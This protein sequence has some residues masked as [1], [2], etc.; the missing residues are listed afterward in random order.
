MR[1]TRILTLPVEGLAIPSQQMTLREIATM[2][3]VF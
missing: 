2:Q 1:V 3:E